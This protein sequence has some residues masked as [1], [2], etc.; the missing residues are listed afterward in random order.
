MANGNDLSK[1][2]LG[3]IQITQQPLG[4]DLLP[5]DP[6]EAPTLSDIKMPDAPVLRGIS[7]IVEFTPQQSKERNI[8]RKYGV[9]PGPGVNVQESAAMLQSNLSKWTNGIIKGVGTA[10]TTFLEPFVDILVGTP[11][12]ISTA[13]V[14]ATVEAY[15]I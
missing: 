3:D 5:K 12:A 8:A 14:I 2:T 6:I 9:T 13:E 4:Q 15:L 7:D 11:T 1:P 10:G